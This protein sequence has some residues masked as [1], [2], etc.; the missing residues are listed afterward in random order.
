MSF[1]D[2]FATFS[3]FGDTKS[4]G[5]SISLSQ[6]DKWMK[7]ADVFDSKTTTT[8]TGI[9][10]KKLKSMKLN[11]N[12]YNTFLEDLTKTK[13]I[14]LAE[15]KNKMANCGEPGVRVVSAVS[16]F[17]YELPEYVSNDRTENQFG[18]SSI[19]TH[20]FYF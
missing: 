11:F 15:I 2:Q 14:N 6:S 8:D 18:F 1:K 5:T 10:F 3:K 4:D 12:D 20:D 9:H 19:Q 7:Q 13:G 16:I 17:M